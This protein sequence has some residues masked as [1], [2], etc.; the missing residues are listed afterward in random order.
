[1]SGK[2]RHDAVASRDNA[3]TQSTHP[4][5]G[6]GAAFQAFFGATI[7]QPNISEAENLWRLIRVILY[8]LEITMGGIK[9]LGCRIVKCCDW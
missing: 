6:G 8:N 1:M 2:H 5:R 7:W 9:W 4:Q 3:P